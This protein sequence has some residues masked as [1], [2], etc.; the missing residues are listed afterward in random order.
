MPINPDHVHLF[1]R[2]QPAY[3]ASYIQGNQRYK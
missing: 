1:I 3:S 2:Y